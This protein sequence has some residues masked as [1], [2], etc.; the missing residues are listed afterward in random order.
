LRRASEVERGKIQFSFEKSAAIA[1][2]FLLSRLI[3]GSARAS[4]PKSGR[5]PAPL[6]CSEPYLGSLTDNLIHFP[7][8]TMK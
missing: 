4:C 6:F 7:F 8:R 3:P 1:A 2:L 5:L